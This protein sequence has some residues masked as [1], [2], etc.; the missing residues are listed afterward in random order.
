MKNGC[1]VFT[2]NN[3]KGIIRKK[4]NFFTANNKKYLQRKGLLMKETKEKQEKTNKTLPS[5]SQNSENSQLLFYLHEAFL[6]LHN[7]AF[8]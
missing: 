7:Q 8:Q 1:K 2:K 6:L 4:Y 3:E 5:S